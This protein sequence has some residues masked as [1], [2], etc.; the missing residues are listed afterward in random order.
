MTRERAE[1]MIDTNLQ[2]VPAPT[3]V[4]IEELLAIINKRPEYSMTKFLEHC[5]SFTSRVAVE[6][7]VLPFQ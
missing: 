6:G 2:K 3:M 7:E 1:A 5:R 4:R